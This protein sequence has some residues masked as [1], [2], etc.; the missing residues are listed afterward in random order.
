MLREFWNVIKSFKKRFVSYY[1]VVL[2]MTF[3]GTFPLMIVKLGAFV[4]FIVASA[5]F[6]PVAASH[7]ILTF[8]QFALHRNR[9]KLPVSAEISRLSKRAGVDV[10]ELGIVKADTAYVMGKSLVL[11]TDL[12]KKLSFDERQAVVAHELGHIKRRHV[13]V[14]SVWVALLF[15][16]LMLSWSKLYSPIFFS[17]PMTQIILTVML[18]IS[19]LAFVFL[20]MIPINWYIELDADR[21][22][23][24][25]VG[26]E[27]IKSALLKFANGK[28]FEE[29]SETHPSI[30]ERVK[31]IE[32]LTD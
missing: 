7:F 25:L 32:K 16:V 22:A 31:R 19:V 11:G 17:E 15:T 10:K 14:R 12:L 1:L 8:K 13:V 23:A 3:F 30:A 6:L 5:F 2:A 21:F 24:E 20:V 29:P 18:N 4:V 27:H 26:K 28:S 9:V